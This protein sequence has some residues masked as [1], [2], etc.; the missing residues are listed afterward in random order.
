MKN[1]N[2]FDSTLQKI[3]EKSILV[4]VFFKNMPR[5]VQHAIGGLEIAE[6]FLPKSSASVDQLVERLTSDPMVMVRFHAGVPESLVKK[7]LMW[8]DFNS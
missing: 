4:F 1:L 3:S 8:E 7:I 6:L 2:V 5:I